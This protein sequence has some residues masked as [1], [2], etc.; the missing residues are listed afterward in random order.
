MCCAVAG[1]VRGTA[2]GGNIT[3]VSLFDSETYAKRL[4]ILKDALPSASKIAYLSP[5]WASEN[6][7]GRALQKSASGSGPA[8]GIVGD[9]DAA[10]RVARA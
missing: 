4:Q 7:G 9:S 5:R 8:I 10:P 2:P 1:L 6:A 3:G